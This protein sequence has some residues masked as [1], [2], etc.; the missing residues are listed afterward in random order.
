MLTKWSDADQLTEFVSLPWVVASSKRQLSLT[1]SDTLRTKQESR[2]SVLTVLKYL[3]RPVDPA[4]SFLDTIQEADWVSAMTECVVG[5]SRDSV[6]T[7][8][9]MTST[10]RVQHLIQQCF[11]VNIPDMALED[12]VFAEADG[13]R[14]YPLLYIDPDEPPNPPVLQ[15]EADLQGAIT[16]Y[17]LLQGHLNTPTMQ[18]ICDLANKEFDGWNAFVS[19]V[20]DDMQT[21]AACSPGCPCGL[22]LKRSESFC[23]YAF[24]SPLPF[25]VRDAS[26]DIRF[27]NFETVR[28]SNIRFYVAFPIIVDTGKTAA[29]LCVL[30]TKPRKVLTTMQYAVMK[31]LAAVVSGI[32]RDLDTSIATK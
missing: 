3:G 27:R 8:S 32:I 14:H 29:L 6:E 2:R 13:T 17:G 23:G 20:N 21:V 19:L 15:S 1:L 4:A 24:A 22:M 25:L 26:L 31:R 11:E 10:E 18:L 28:G 9:S 12:C 5:T 16:K 7:E 30:D